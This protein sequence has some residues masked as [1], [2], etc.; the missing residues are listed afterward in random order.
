MR[1]YPSPRERLESKTVMIPFCTCHIFTGFRLKKG[2][3]HIRYNGSLV[4]A[5]R[6]SYEL[7]VGKIPDGMIVCHSCDEPS[8][9]NPDHLFIGTHKDNSDDKI[10]KGRAVHPS[11]KDSATSK[12][13][14]TQVN[15]IRRI[16]LSGSTFK[17]ISD[18]FGVHLSTIHRAATY[19]TWKEQS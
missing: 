3:G 12:L 6:M 8:C 4:V 17:D 11:G 10:R 19:K 7:N 13:S 18:L 9:V 1:A 5:H 2:Y 16:R 15:E 14:E